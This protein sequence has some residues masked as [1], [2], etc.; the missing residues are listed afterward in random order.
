[1][2]VLVYSQLNKR[3]SKI[4]NQ[5]IERLSAFYISYFYVNFN[6]LFNFLNSFESLFL[7]KEFYLLFN[8]FIGI[9]FVIFHKLLIKNQLFFPLYYLYDL[10]QQIKYRHQKLQE[11]ITQ[12]ILLI[13][14]FTIFKKFQIFQIKK[15]I[16][17]LAN[18]LIQKIQ[19]IYDFKY[20]LQDPKQF[21]CLFIYF[22]YFLKKLYF[23]LYLYNINSGKQ[24]INNFYQKYLISS[25]II[26]YL[27][28]QINL[29]YFMD[30]LNDITKRIFIYFQNFGK[31]SYFFE[32]SKYKIQFLLTQLNYPLPKLLISVLLL[33]LLIFCINLV[34]RQSSG[35]TKIQIFYQINLKKKKMFNC[36]QIN[37]D[38]DCSVSNNLM[39]SNQIKLENLV[40]LNYLPIKL[41][42]QLYL[43]SIQK[44]FQLQQIKLLHENQY[45]YYFQIGGNL[46]IIQ[47]G[48]KQN[49]EKFL[50]FQFQIERL[51]KF[52]ENQGCSVL[53]YS[54]FTFDLQDQQDAF[55]VYCIAEIILK[56]F[57]QFKKVL[58]NNQKELDQ[59]EINWNSMFE[60]SECNTVNQTIKTAFISQNYNFM[61]YS[62]LNI[63]LRF[64]QIEQEGA[65]I[66]SN[67]LISLNKIKPILKLQLNLYS[68]TLADE[69]VNSLSQAFIQLQYLQ[70]LNLILMINLIGDNGLRHLASNLSYLQ[71]LEI[72]K[73]NLQNNKF[74]DAGVAY[75]TKCL[76]NLPKLKDLELDLYFNE[77][78]KFGEIIGMEIINLTDLNR[79][80]ISFNKVDQ[81]NTATLIEGILKLNHLSSL[82]LELQ[83]CLIDQK[84]IDV[85]QLRPAE[86]FENILQIELILQYNQ[87]G[88]IG[89]CNLF[90]Y[91]SQLTKIQSIHLNLTA[92]SIINGEFPEEYQQEQGQ[93][94]SLVFL[95]INLCWCQV[96]LRGSKFIGKLI[97]NS[98][99]LQDLTLAFQDNQIN[100]NGLK[101]L[102]Q[103][104]SLLTSL[105]RLK[106][107]LWGCS[108]QISDLGLGYLSENVL[109]NTEIISLSLILVYGVFTIKGLKTLYKNLKQCQKLNQIEIATYT[110]S[111]SQKDEDKFG[112]WIKKFKRLCNYNNFLLY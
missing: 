34:A 11:Y 72:L 78:Q 87:I 8:Y 98:P 41:L 104:I 97:Q 85:F 112:C 69:G 109:K 31:F 67:S 10:T 57:D 32:V 2:F 60:Y 49:Y 33:F 20:Q 15:V 70:S 13:F 30:C 90:Y 102:S 100:D 54:D 39:D 86:C 1:M 3:K 81:N 76:K 42:Q 74:G 22:Y 82:K 68:N 50:E 19:L 111:V 36:Q 9:F 88:A 43:L 80:S 25:L 75:L 61:K 12:N 77:T 46:F 5:F 45:G 91:F 65:K 6:F 26:Y 52:L 66:I 105:K 16:K 63:A 47:K 4:N 56:D 7:N 18:L 71:S 107:D 73:L 93:F 48:Q 38:Q 62:Q 96:G 83:N 103:S 84:W 94:K 92:N 79:L 44:D 99:L 51:V 23:K 21:I 59:E 53:N 35:K 55:Q 58:V 64:C 14:L 89:F 110:I 40:K 24:F 106:F 27:F 29:I 101:I 28:I 108:N 17:Q 37:N 95:Y